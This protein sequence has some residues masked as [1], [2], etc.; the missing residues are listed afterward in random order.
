MHYLPLVS[1]AALVACSAPKGEPSLHSDSKVVEW[2]A[3][4]DTTKLGTDGTAAMTVEL[5]ATIADGWHIYSVGQTSGG[6]V[7]MT[8][9]VSPPY[10]VAGEIQA[11][12][13][14]KARDPNFGIETETYSG[15]QIFR[16]PLKLAATSSVSPPPI[17]L[18]VRSQACSDKLCL[19]AKVTTLT[20]TPLAG[21]L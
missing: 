19:P 20:V 3:I 21:T 13:P 12:T 11:P 7:P 15:E 14:V 6:P 5:Q 16:I 1:I 8:V 9:K 4:A 10:E 18:K 17:E 2:A